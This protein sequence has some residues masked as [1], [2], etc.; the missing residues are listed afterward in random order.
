M[1]LLGNIRPLTGFIGA[2]IAGMD[3]RRIGPAEVSAIR[4]A[5]REHQVLFF[6]RQNL[7]PDD[8]VAAASRFGE[9]DPPHGGLRHHPD[10]PNVMTAI[11]V[12]GQGGGKF[13]AIW[14]S[15]VTFDEAPPMASMLQAVTL[16][17]LGGDTLFI[18]MYAAWERLSPVLQNAVEGLEA[19][20]DGVPD[21]T[22]YLLDPGTP[23]GPERLE[24]MRAEKPGFVHPL[25]VRHPESRRKALFVNRAFTQQIIGLPEIESRHLLNLLCEHCEQATHQVRWHWNQGDIAFWDNRCTMHYAAMDYGDHERVMHRV[26]LKGT[27]PLAA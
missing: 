4:D 16:P 26:T 6:P 7:S 10:N 2:E 21:F 20:H 1:T 8:L 15:D 5:F 25:V 24:K 11:T 23:N 14:H 22:R 27:R 17:P 12:K 3:L 13:N 19:L 18:S 9:I